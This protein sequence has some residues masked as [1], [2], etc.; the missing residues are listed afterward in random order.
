MEQ[1]SATEEIV[2]AVEEEELAEFA[3]LIDIPD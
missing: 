3:L 1:M 2:E